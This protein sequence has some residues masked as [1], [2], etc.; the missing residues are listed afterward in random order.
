M[1]WYASRNHNAEWFLTDGYDESLDHLEDSLEQPGGFRHTVLIGTL[2]GFNTATSGGYCFT[3]RDRAF[4][5]QKAW[6]GIEIYNMTTGTKGMI[7]EVSGDQ[8]CTTIWFNPGDFYTIW[9]R[10]AWILANSDGPIIEID[11]RRCGFSY[12][13]KELVRGLCKWCRDKR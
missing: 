2:T 4:A 5:T 10:E 6:P 11:C 3:D 12:P 1:T 9:L 13:R 7:L 8:L